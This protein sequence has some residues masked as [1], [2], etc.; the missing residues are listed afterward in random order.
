MAV[1]PCEVMESV[2]ALEAS[3]LQSLTDHEVLVDAQA[4]VEVEQQRSRI[5]DRLDAV[6][7][8]EISCRLSGATWR[9]VLQEVGSEVIT[10][11]SAGELVAIARSCVLHFADLAPALRAEREEPRRIAITWSSALR[12]WAARGKVRFILVNDDYLCGEILA[13]G[14]DCVDLRLVDGSSITLMF[15]GIKVAIRNR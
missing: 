2:V 6:R 13:V 3:R 7:G 1:D 15:S 4:I 12:A 10:V 11:D 9:G 8:L 5:S 14:G